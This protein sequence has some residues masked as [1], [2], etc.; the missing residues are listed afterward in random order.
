MARQL[1]A[2]ATLA[3]DLSLIPAPTLGSQC[4]VTVPSTGL[5]G[6]LHSNAHTHTKTRTNTCN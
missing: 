4:L 3:E 2:L 1:K 6:Y 5:L